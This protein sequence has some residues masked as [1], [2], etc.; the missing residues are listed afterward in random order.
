MLGFKLL[1]G[2][3]KGKNVPESTVESG[4]KALGNRWNNM[5]EGNRV[6]TGVDMAL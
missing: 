3:V 5:D 2:S 1:N 6:T 4:S